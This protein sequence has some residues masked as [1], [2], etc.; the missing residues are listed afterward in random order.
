LAT[1]NY[2]NDKLIIGAI[3][4]DMHVGGGYSGNTVFTV[5]V[6]DSL[7]NGKEYTSFL[8]AY[9]RKYP[10]PSY[11][12]AFT[13]WLRQDE[14]VPFN[15]WNN[16]AALRVSPI[17]LACR[18]L[19]EVLNEAGGN[20]SISHSHPDGIKGAQ[21]VASAV[22]LARNGRS[23]EEIRDYIESE[24]GYNLHRT[25][26]D[27]RPNYYYDQSCQGSVPQSIIAF[28]ESKD[29]ESAISIAGSLKGGNNSIASITGGIAQAYYK[30][31]PGHMARDIAEALPPDLYEIVEEFSKTFPLSLF[32]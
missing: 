11:G 4:G 22:F 1:I 14:P 31:I 5:A 12:P 26:E 21:A 23:K 7:L 29:Y 24:F 30:E 10:D 9:G 16:G 32:R 25:I 3:A 13:R 27:I 2:S 6:M 8:Q 18:T 17:G 19:K 15:S 28:L 20:A